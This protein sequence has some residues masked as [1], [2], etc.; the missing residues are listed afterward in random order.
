MP[1]RRARPLTVRPI[2]VSDAIDGTNAFPGAMA[3]L[4][5]LIPAPFNRSI[6]VPRPASSKTTNFG[7]FTG[8]AQ[9][10][11][12]LVIG[13]RIY[14][15]IASTHFA[16]KSEPFCYDLA[17][18]AFISISGVASALLPSTQARTGDWQPPHLEMVGTRIIVTSPGFSGG[19]GP[20]F[21]WIDLSGFSDNALTCT[22]HG[23]TTLDTFS[24]DPLAAGVRP[25]QTVTGTDFAAGTY[26]VS[27]TSTTVTIS[28]NAT[29]SHSALAVTFAGGTQ[30]APLWGAGN[31]N[32]HPLVAVPNWVS[33][34]NGRAYYAV[35]NT[36]VFSDSLDP[37]EITNASQIL[38]FGDNTA[39]TCSIGLPLQ[40]MVVGGVVQSLIVVK[41][42]AVMYQV[43]G[44]AATTNLAQNALNVAIGTLAP[45]SMC[46]T[47][48]GIAFVA[49]DG[50]RIIDFQAQV[51]DP[52]GANGEGVNVPFINA[53]FPSRMCAAFNQ[54]T[55][56]ISVQNGLVGGTPFQEFWFNFKL[57]AWT[58]P[59]SFPMALI[60]PCFYNNLGFVSAAI[61]IDAA[62]WTSQ[63]IPTA[64]SAYVENGATL[65]CTYQTV[66]LPDNEMMAMNAIIQSNVAL[67][68]PA[69]SQ[70]TV[71]ALNEVGLA[72]D[73]VYIVAPP[74]STMTWGSST[75]GS[76]TTW[77]T[78][79]GYF[80]QYTIPWNNP[81]VFK[82]MSITIT[83]AAAEGFAIGNLYLKY[84]ILGYTLDVQTVIVAPIQAPMD[85]V[86][87]GGVIITTEGGVPIQTE[88]IPG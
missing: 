3:A 2:G 54:N 31:T 55:L 12:C 57:K 7:T 53:L 88:G 43:T 74:G 58:G 69:N 25:G 46:P 73:P 27:V 77:G 33:Q 44:D 67:Q 32:T 60:Q 63:A 65:A 40:N 15:L 36:E 5:N 82:Q 10:E 11:A 35:Q 83:G 79:F 84:Q 61:G 19:S 8:P 39:V 6:F 29:G 41:G 85:I 28:Q 62:L 30:A 52:I 37:L 4:T 26:V 68:L 71:Q 78:Q 13:S 22:T 48:L 66:L 75:W 56:R 34:F 49:P 16:G 64:T 80:Q 47:P 14:G 20:F 23:T 45:N 18:S 1:L 17:T 59:H 72:L 21:G 76:P 24:A 51:G 50:L 86:T 9:V 87:E 81:L 70:V 42:A 38:T